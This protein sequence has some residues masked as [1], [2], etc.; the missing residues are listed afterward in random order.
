MP[1]QTMVSG[2]RLA[3]TGRGVDL[4]GLYG[5]P[6]WMVQVDIDWRTWTAGELRD[7]PPPGT[8]RNAR[9]PSG[10][11]ELVQR[12]RATAE[13]VHE[14]PR[15]MVWVL[16]LALPSPH[17]KKQNS[18]LLRARTIA[19]MYRAAQGRGLVPKRVIAEV[20][21][22]PLDGAQRSRKLER[23]IEQARKTI[24]P[25]TGKPCLPPYVA[26]RD[27]PRQWPIGK[28]HPLAPRRARP[29]RPEPVRE[30]LHA[31]RTLALSVARLPPPAWA[32]RE[33]EALGGRLIGTDLV[34]TGSWSDGDALPPL[35]LLKEVPPGEV[36]RRIMTLKKE[37]E[38]TYPGAKVT[39]TIPLQAMGNSD[40][41]VSVSK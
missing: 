2:V 17:G 32:L 31:G 38:Q 28:D 6:G 4:R 19:T 25:D 40:S 15:S 37:L 29:L 27:A 13:A 39:A 24:D 14:A 34:V 1:M 7:I 12:I 3:I 20:Y 35:P 21:G 8:R 9:R 16:S 41:P 36:P 26:E 18:V 10:D 23:W 5:W 33:A 30:G 22:I 11:A